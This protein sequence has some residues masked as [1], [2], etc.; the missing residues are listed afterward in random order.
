MAYG[1]ITAVRGLRKLLL[2]PGPVVIISGSKVMK[3]SALENEYPGIGRLNYFLAHIAM[4]AVV[5]IAV[6]FAGTD[7]TLF[8]LLSLAAM[9]AGVLLDVMRLRN[10]GVSQWFALLRFVPF[11][12]SLLAVGLQSAQ[13]GWIETRRLDRTGWA[14]V[15]VHAALFIFILVISFYPPGVELRTLVYKLFA[16][17]V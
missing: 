11:V 17:A 16:G 9:I 13:T 4:I 1:P 15:G 10:I 3:D 12:S 6:I 14:I 7:S 5:V 8:R 2:R